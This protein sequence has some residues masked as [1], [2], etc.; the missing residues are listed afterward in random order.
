MKKSKRM[1]R[2]MGLPAQLSENVVN[3]MKDPG[4]PSRVGPLTPPAAALV[5]SEG[6][7]KES[8]SPRPESGG[9]RRPSGAEVD[10]LGRC[11]REQAVVQDELLQ[12]ATRDIEAAARPR[13]ASL[14]QGEGGTDPG[15][16]WSAQLAGELE[17]REAELRRRDALYKEQLG[18]LE[19]MSRRTDCLHSSSTR[20]PRR[21][22]VR[23][24]PAGWSPC[25]RGCRPRSCAATASACRRCC[26]VRT[27]SRPTSTA[28]ARRTRV[29]A[30]PLR[31]RQ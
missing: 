9:G 15:T 18:R 29:D 22:R 10:R 8:K 5:S 13:S 14:R 27:W 12:V 1:R 24:S 2:V 17:S 28:S 16:Q 4:Q 3:R 11:D 23:S 7:E 25:A 26:C 31:A 20:Q 6:R 30:G 21:W 19:R